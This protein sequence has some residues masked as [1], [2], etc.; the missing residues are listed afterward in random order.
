M[1]IL[2]NETAKKNNFTFYD[3][4]KEY[5]TIS[6]LHLK[7]LTNFP[8]TSDFSP[9][10]IK[11]LNTNLQKLDWNI[12]EGTLEAQKLNC[13]YVHYYPL[14]N[15]T[16]LLILFDHDNFSSIFH[17]VHI[18]AS[19]VMNENLRNIS[20]LSTQGGPHCPGYVLKKF[21]KKLNPDARYLQILAGSGKN[22]VIQTALGNGNF[23]RH[24]W[25]LVTPGVISRP[26]IFA[27]LTSA[28]LPLFQHNLN[29]EKFE[30]YDGVGWV[31]SG[32]LKNEVNLIHTILPPLLHTARNF[33]QIQPNKTDNFL[34]IGKDRAISKTGSIVLGCLLVMLIWLPVANQLYEGNSIRFIFS[35]FF[36][37]IY[38]SV[39][40]FLMALLSKMLGFLIPES[41]YGTIVISVIFIFTS[42]F[43]NK[44][45]KSIFNFNASPLAEFCVFLV[46]ASLL[47]FNN[48][49]LF[50]FIIPVVFM[51]STKSG[52]GFKVFQFLIFVSLLPLI[53][54]I[55]TAGSFMHPSDL[56]SHL[57]LT[58]LNQTM[59]SNLGS[60]G[61]LFFLSGSFL[62][63][64]R[65]SG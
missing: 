37:M 35:A 8:N 26:S 24:D 22:I 42:W 34:W 57:S 36:S 33:H 7:I 13:K 41:L 44:I 51:A 5:N 59:F 63:V 58:W 3:Q 54:A 55:H 12:E 10:I 4:N 53:Y 11:N 40:F 29:M 6:A 23:S 14:K 15:K 27:E 61:I 20:I 16:R 56:I 45:Q 17:L 30:K 65:K 28:A 1:E 48:L 60:T 18:F 19:A 9:V 49:S 21:E 46:F 31:F 2:S 64:F 50:I 47:A 38:Q 43:F 32:D 39:P 62:S 52:V 25:S